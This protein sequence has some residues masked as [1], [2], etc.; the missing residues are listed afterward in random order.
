M[1]RWTVVLVENIGWWPRAAACYFGEVGFFLRK[2]FI[3][4]WINW[5]GWVR[6]GEMISME[7]PSPDLYSR[8]V[9]AEL[10]VSQLEVDAI[11][12]FVRIAQLFGVSKSIGE[13]YGLL[14]ISPAPI[15]VE[16]IRIK[17][18]M[19]SGSASQGLALLRRVHAVRTAYQA[20]ERRDYYVA[21][22]GLA[23]IASGF[24]REKIA[25]H[26][27]DQEDRIVRLAN[28]LMETPAMH[29]PLLAERIEILQSWRRQARAVLPMVLLGLERGKSHPLDTA[30]FLK[31]E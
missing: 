25:P 30:A 31:S 5:G 11:D 8:N 18:R 14:F 23:K 22:T 21:E 13:I 28:L 9:R 27:S 24:L 26:L 7:G 12:F 17:L 4:G 16:E 19:S 10:D 29:R 15:S 20:G 3:P 1:R 6:L 2:Q